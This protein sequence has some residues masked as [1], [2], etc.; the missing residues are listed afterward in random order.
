MSEADV[1]PRA[2]GLVDRLTAVPGVIAVVLG[3]SRAIGRHRPDSDV[4]L[5]LYY[6]G[7]LD[8]AA[9]RALAAEDAEV[10]GVSEPGG[11]GPWVDGGAWLVVDGIR[12]DWIY[13][14]VDRVARIWRDCRAGRYEIGVQAGHPLGF[15]SHGYPGEVALCQLLADPTGELAALRVET[16]RYPDALAAALVA[17]VWEPDLLLYGA[18]SHGTAAVEPWF[19]AGCL[20]RALGVL[21]HALL[22]HHRVWIT[23][24]KRL[25]EAAGEL[26]GAPPQFTRRAH[27]ILGRIGTTGDE[28]AAT[29]DAAR[30]L[31][32]D[33]IQRLPSKPAALPL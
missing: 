18:A 9:L 17:A 6:R 22:G 2:L 16:Q 30:G 32:A 8:V 12:V 5:G 4:D 14:D 15:Y 25:L 24:E 19:T 20:F 21:G 33:T 26:P 11:W 10:L 23:H 29:V 3:G 27:A 31:V 13:R 7:A 28:I 1:P